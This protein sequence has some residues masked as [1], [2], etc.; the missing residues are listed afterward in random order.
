MKSRKN[1]FLFYFCFFSPLSWSQIQY[2]PLSSF[3]RHE[4]S[5]GF[6]ISTKNGQKGLSDHLPVF[7]LKYTFYFPEMS[8]ILPEPYK[9]FFI[10]GFQAGTNL[11]RTKKNYGICDIKENIHSGAYH[12]GLKGKSPYFEFLQPFVE[13]GLARSFCYSKNLSKTSKAKMKLSHYFSYGL[14]LSFKILDRE[15]I[16]AL[17]QDYGINDMGIKM[18]CLHYYPKSKKD[19]SFRLCQLGFQVSF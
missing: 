18:E 10:P 11:F 4:L 19:K 12:F 2:R 14:F 13:G 6:S 1:F 15:S 17:D 5:S 8:V 3:E 9:N 7:F 16:Y